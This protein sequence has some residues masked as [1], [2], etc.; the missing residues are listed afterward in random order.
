MKKTLG[1]VLYPDFEIL[2]CAGPIEMFGN[3]TEQLELVVVGPQAGPVRST[4]GVS[5]HADFGLADAPRLDLLL[6]PGG[7]GTLAEVANQPFLAWLRE[8]AATAELVMT[9]CSG[10]AILA[11]A[12]LL[13]GKR[14]T[15]NKAWF[16]TLTESTPAVRWVP[17]AR[18]VE[19][20]KFVTSS[21]VSAG[22]DMAL[23]VIAARFGQET[24]DLLATMTE[25]DWH[26]DPDWDPFAAVH[27]L[28]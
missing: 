27:G 11:V 2:D 16:T 28:V 4:Q 17:K 19:D 23:A 21:G 12:G 13:D 15:T 10:S 18:W 25:Y 1:I 8:R 26:R 14:A 7:N 22:I 6:L 3:C 24:S 9:V 20:G 5:I